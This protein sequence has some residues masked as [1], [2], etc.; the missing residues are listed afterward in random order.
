MDLSVVG[1][2]MEQRA[3]LDTLDKVN[4]SL[5][6]KT[7]EQAQSQAIQLLESVV[8]DTT[9][10]EGSKGSQINTAV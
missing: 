6:K 5:L 1:Q 7:N 8:P 9:I 4:V 2:V 3:T 10:S